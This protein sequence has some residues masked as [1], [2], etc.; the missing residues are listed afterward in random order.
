MSETL[1]GK[2]GIW[3]WFDEDGTKRLVH[4]CDVG[5]PKGE[6]HLRVAWWGGYYRISDEYDPKHPEN[7]KYTAAE[8]PDRWGKYIGHPESVL[9]D[10]LY[11]I[12]TPEQMEEIFK[13]HKKHT[14]N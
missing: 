12:P 3:E 2:P 11:R 1:P 4:V 6:Q 9:E 5:V 8:W 14:E 10:D 7:D 13:S